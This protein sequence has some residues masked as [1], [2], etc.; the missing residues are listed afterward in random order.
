MKSRASVIVP[1]GLLVV[2]VVLAVA[3]EMLD[4]AGRPGGARLSYQ[5][6]VF[7]PEV[8]AFAGSGAL[9][10]WRRSRHPAGW[11]LLAVGLVWVTVGALNAFVHYGLTRGDTDGTSVQALAAWLLNWVWVLAF[12]AVGLFFLLFPDGQLPGRRWRMALWVGAA[13][14][15]LVLISRA[16][17]PGPLAEMPAIVNPLG[18]TRA[19]VL[20]RIAE[21]VGNP[22]IALADTAAIASLFFRFRRADTLQRRQLLWMAVA[23]AACCALMFTG[24]VLDLTG[25]TWIDAGDLYIASFAGIPVAA[26]VAILR[27]RLFDIDLVIGKTIVY[28]GVFGFITVVFLVLVVGVGAV[29]GHGTGS[30]VLLA[31]LATALAGLGA[32]PLR[33]RLQRLARRVVYPPASAPERQAE[34]AIRAFGAFRV[35][36][37]G[38]TVPASAWQSKK[39]RTLVKILVARRGRATNREQLMEILW[40]GESPAIVTRRLSVALATARAVLD[41]GRLYPSEQ[42]IVADNDAI[43]LNLDH[44][45]V[46]VEEF[47]LYAAAGLAAHREDRATDARVPLQMAETAY[48]GDFL[49][50]DRYE[51][52]AVPTREDAL[53]TYHA[54]AMSLAE[55]SA[56]TGDA[57]AAVRCYL[58]VLE[59]DEYD[60]QAHLG[61]VAILE[62]DGRR[63]EARRRYRTYEDRMAELG[64]PAAMFPSDG[65]PRAPEAARRN[66]PDR[67]PR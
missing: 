2:T 58:R 46:D 67:N 14:S 33:L 25:A 41:P 30:N 1:A 49:E 3:A 6:V 35:I 28:G 50:E 42:Y 13:G 27:F 24:N 9:I 37:G 56:R 54:V 48:A 38:E 8:L 43:R 36:L 17:T 23:G 39:A 52:W 65:N 51:D 53:A 45:R 64:V 16:F 63:G 32:Q 62:R 59:R 19:D 60:E 40:P 15:I 31:V 34:V 20:L 7:F 44:A 57:D 18:L 29:V 61:M 10:A 22:L 12:V 26:S 47:M 21:I 11:L 66:L 5:D 4:L 55:I